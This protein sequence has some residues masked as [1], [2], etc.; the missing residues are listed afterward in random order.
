MARATG[1]ALPISLKKSILVCDS[2]RGKQLEKAI[3]SLER[4]IMMEKPVQ[5]RR[6]NKGGTGHKP[7]IGPGRYPVK[8]CMEIKKILED[9]KANAENKGLQAK[10][11]IID[12]I[13]AKKGS[14]SFHYGRKRR[15]LMKRTHIEIVVKE[16]TIKKAIKK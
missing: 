11:L 3:A 13:S 12:H 2:I 4:V 8:T 6:F 5:Y 14:K 10:N 1:L 16:G 15:R 9:A 7:G